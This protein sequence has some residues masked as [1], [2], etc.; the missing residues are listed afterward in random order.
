MNRTGKGSGARV[1]ELPQRASS[2]GSD[3]CGY[4]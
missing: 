4:R 3:F 2:S 1:A